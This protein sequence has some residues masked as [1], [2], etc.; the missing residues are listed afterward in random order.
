MLFVADYLLCHATEFKIILY[1]VIMTFSPI[2][3]RDPTETFDSWF[4]TS[5]LFIGRNVGVDHIASLNLSMVPW[6]SFS[7]FCMEIFITILPIGS[8]SSV[9]F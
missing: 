1:A 6:D 7:F 5:M 9:P 8:S 4:F 2:N 3:P